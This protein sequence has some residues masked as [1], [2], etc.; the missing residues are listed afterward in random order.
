MQFYI[1]GDAAQA[2]SERM[3][4]PKIPSQKK[5]YNELNKRLAKYVARVQAIYDSL[6]DRVALNVE[7]LDYDGSVPFSFGDYP[8]TR[9][10]VK[11]IQSQFVSDIGNLIYRGTSDEWKR[12]NTMQDLL[13]DKVLKYYDAEI[14]GEKRRVYYQDNND[15]L[16]AF[17]QRK[18]RGLNLSSKLWRQSEA[19]KTEMECAISTA[20]EKGTSAITLNKMLSRYLKD[21]PSMQRDYKDKFG[22]AADC[23]DCE[24]RSIRLARSEINMAYRTAEQKRWQQFDFIQGYEIKLSKAHK[25]DDVCDDLKGKY[26]KNFVWA[27]WH[28][29]DMCYAVPIIASEDEYWGTERDFPYIVSLPNEFVEWTVKNKMRIDQAKNRGTLPY[30]IRDNK[31]LIANASTKRDVFAMTESIKK[32]LRQNGFSNFDADKYNTSAL[33]GFDVAAFDKRIEKLCDEHGILIDGKF[34]NIYENGNATIRYVGDFGNEDFE[35]TRSFII[36]QNT[37]RVYVHHDL[38]YLPEQIQ[39]KGFAKAVFK[40]SYE[41]YKK[42]GIYGISLLAN[43]DVGGYA[44]GRYGFSASTE[45]L[46]SVVKTDKAMKFI[47]EWSARNSDK[48]RMPV[49]L[50]AEQPYGKKSL[51]GT[52]WHGWLNLDNSEEC[53]W[54][55]EYIGITN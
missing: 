7:T 3:G 53:H 18:D 1:K 15:A 23:H 44:W 46:L 43:I 47:K 26:P 28:P 42:C 32:E 37:G 9:E 13:A 21:F 11:T 35:I 17:Q 16:K 20:I 30:F 50:I 55:E 31:S 34:I 2:N 10:L 51:F 33:K 6:S 49:R 8:E 19:Y 29:N 41:Q 22:S 39:G 52:H 27:G 38:F 24:Y 40:E 4:K 5:A 54:L 12:S 14:H 36:E 48:K 45:E 25:T